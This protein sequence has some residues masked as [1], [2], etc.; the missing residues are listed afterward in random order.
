M[1]EKQLRCLTALL[2]LSYQ[3]RREVYE[4]VDELGVLSKS[5]KEALE[6]QRKFNLGPMSS[7][8]CP[9]CGK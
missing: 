2:T 1:T 6:Y 3:E 7:A 8:T 5:I 9:Y 4:A